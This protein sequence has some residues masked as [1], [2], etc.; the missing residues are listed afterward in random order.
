MAVNFEA[1]QAFQEGADNR[2][3]KVLFQKNLKPETDVR[4]L[5]PL[6]DS[7]PYFFVKEISYWIGGERYLSPKTFNEPCPIE[8]EVNEARKLRD[9]SINHLLADSKGFSMREEY[10]MA[11]LELDCT[12]SKGEVVDVQPIG[13]PKIFKCTTQLLSSINKIALSPKYQN[14]TE[15]GFCDLDQ[16]F[17]ITLIKE[18]GAQ[19]KYSADP[20]R[21]PFLIPDEWIQEIPDVIENI[22]NQMKSEEELRKAIRDYLYGTRPPV[23]VAA[24]QRRG[25][26]V[27]APTTPSRRPARAATTVAAPVESEVE[28]YE[29]EGEKIDLPVTP[30]PVTTRAPRAPRAAAPPVVETQAEEA[31]Q[32]VQTSG[33]V[34]T[35]RSLADRLNSL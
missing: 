13:V 20:H 32:P 21:S 11:I 17:N 12:Y 29:S 1:L 4:I 16:G 6:D 14:G 3:G 30:A 23:A 33:T 5:P 25:A 7:M 19:T 31:E 26:A 34:S 35:R 9:A 22:E 15:N 18:V 27:A 24:P 8:E 2:G 28:Q 10:S